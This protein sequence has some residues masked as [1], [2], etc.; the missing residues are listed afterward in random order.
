MISSYILSNEGLKQNYELCFVFLEFTD[1]ELIRAYC[2]LV[3]REKFYR[4]HKLKENGFQ[5][6]KWMKLEICVNK[7]KHFAKYND[8]NNQPSERQKQMIYKLEKDG[9]EVESHLNQEFDTTLQLHKNVLENMT[10][11]NS[12]W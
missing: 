8:E 11:S 12:N 3:K 9:F 1:N 4:Y 2:K 7:N 6:L 10:F 5:L